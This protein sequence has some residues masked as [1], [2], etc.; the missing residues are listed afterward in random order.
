MMSSF[1]IWSHSI[2]FQM[3]RRK[4]PRTSPRHLCARAFCSSVR[5][6]RDGSA[7]YSVSA[8]SGIG[9]P[10]RA[11]HWVWMYCLATRKYSADAWGSCS[12]I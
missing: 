4:L 3:V 11:C 10:W 7:M 5:S 1:S 2:T 12:R 9:V 8:S 6:P